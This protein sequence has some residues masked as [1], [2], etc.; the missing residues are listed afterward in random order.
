MLKAQLHAAAAAAAGMPEEPGLSSQQ[1]LT[2]VHGTP[3]DTTQQQHNQVSG[4]ENLPGLPDAPAATAAVNPCTDQS[5]LTR[6]SVFA[7]YCNTPLAEPDP[8]EEA[9]RRCEAALCSTEAV[10]NRNS[11]ATD[12]VSACEGAE[13]SVSHN[14]AT[15]TAATAAHLF[16]QAGA[17]AGTASECRTPVALSRACS[18]ATAFS[19]AE[20]GPYAP[21]MLTGPQA[22]LRQHTLV[23]QRTLKRQASRPQD[24]MCSGPSV[25]SGPSMAAECAQQLE[26]QQQ[27]RQQHMQVKSDP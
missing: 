5:T 3:L 6:R 17:A 27:Q 24:G 13:Q 9:M 11:E 21:G 10:L 1:P 14:P 4:A 2:S 16:G 18:S 7:D 22:R 19:N 25:R 20:R 8:C 26:M 12:T 15:A 23:R